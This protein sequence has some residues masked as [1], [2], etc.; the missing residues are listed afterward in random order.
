VITSPAWRVHLGTAEATVVR[1]V[2]HPTRGG[3]GWPL[4]RLLADVSGLGARRVAAPRAVGSG[5]GAP[6]IH[7]TELRWHACDVFV[8]ARHDSASGRHEVSIELPPWDELCSR[9]EHEAELWDLLDVVAA[10]SD[11]QHG[12]IGD[13]EATEL[14]LPEDER[15]WEQRCRRHIGVLAPA[16]V[17]EMRLRSACVYR[18]LPQSGLCMFLR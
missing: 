4:T 17:A 15:E 13:G 11:A 14:E 10:A 12:T 16:S 9:V 6:L 1:L 3:E 7:S 5:R 8:E 2:S 18:A